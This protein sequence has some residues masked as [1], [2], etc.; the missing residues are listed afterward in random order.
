MT[1]DKTTLVTA[2]LEKRRPGSGLRAEWAAIVGF[3]FILCALTLVRRAL[4]PRGGPGI[5]TPALLIT[6]SEYAVWMLL[7]PAIFK[8]AQRYPLERSTWVKSTIFHLTIAFIVAAAV[9]LIRVVVIAPLMLPSEL[10]AAEPWRTDAL[11]ALSRLQF[12]DELIIY[13]A[14]MATGFARDYFLRYRERQALAAHLE[15]QLSEARLSALRMQ[16]N[17]HFL[18]NTLHVV[19]TLV[20]RDPPGARRIVAKLSTLLRRVLEESDEQEARLG[21]ELHFLRSYMEIQHV[22]FGDRLQFVENV[23]AELFD[24]RIPTLILQPLVENAIEHGV[25]QIEDT[26]EGRVELRVRRDGDSLALEVTDN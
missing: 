21:D 5:A 22:R 2:S 25:S 11:G 15:A 24:A 20:D 19:S 23:D 13:L 1:D 18:F 6:L 26:G 7:T 16:L 10:L 17:P 8:L 9:D 14:V 3:W 4:D 12:L